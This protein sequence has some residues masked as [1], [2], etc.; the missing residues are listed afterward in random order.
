MKSGYPRDFQVFTALESVPCSAS[1]DDIDDIDDTY[2]HT[3]HA[4]VYLGKTDSSCQ[5]DN[6]DPIFVLVKLR[7]DQKLE[8]NPLK[9]GF[10][11]KPD[12]PPSL[13]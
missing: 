2:R 10:S 12:T 11:A 4:W 3:E 6:F 1:R 7:M 13:S 8:L 5:C 9:G